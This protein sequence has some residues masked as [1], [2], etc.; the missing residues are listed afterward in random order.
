ME[1]SA[2]GLYAGHGVSRWTKV[3]LLEASNVGTGAPQLSD[4]P[5]ESSPKRTIPRSRKT[6]GDLILI[7][8]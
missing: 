3:L 8:L 2:A 5:R 4:P 6:A 1:Q 7:Y